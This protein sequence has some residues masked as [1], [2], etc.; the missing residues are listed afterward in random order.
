M[1]IERG[2]GTQDVWRDVH[3]PNCAAF[4]AKFDHADGRGYLRCRSCPTWFIVEFHGNG[5]PTITPVQKKG[6]Q[7]TA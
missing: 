7:M 4:V 5:A 3:C 6:T 1:T 2:N